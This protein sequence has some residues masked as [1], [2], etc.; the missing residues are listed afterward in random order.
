MEKK[1]LLTIF[2]I[3]FQKLWMLLL[4]L[5]LVNKF[6]SHLPTPTASLIE[7]GSW[8]KNIDE[9]R[10]VSWNHGGDVASIFP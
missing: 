9:K 5:S 6:S 3:F 1:F 7:V 4:F 10:S 2:K 8:I